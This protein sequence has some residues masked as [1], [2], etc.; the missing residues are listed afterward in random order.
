MPH[1][2]YTVSNT[3]TAVNA[4]PSFTRTVSNCKVYQKL[5][6]LNDATQTWVD[7]AANT[8]L[9]PFATFA[10]GLNT[11][12]TNIGQLTVQATRAL[13]IPSVSWKPTKTYKVKIT[14]DDPDANHLQL[15]TYTFDLEL[16]DICADNALTKTSDLTQVTTHII[17]DPVDTVLTPL[18]TMSVAAAAG[19]GCISVANMSW[20]NTFTNVYTIDNDGTGNT[21]HAFV[22]TFSTVN[23]QL[24]ISTNDIA[25]YSI[26]KLFVMKI[27]LNLPE[28]ISTQNNIEF[29]FQVI[30]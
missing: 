15:L 8:A 9:Y 3:N 22:K 14:L 30:I 10:D 11:A 26:S 23:G 16:R 25:K 2:R 1:W 13:V 28:S 17:E 4:S 5:Y 20:L 7:Y 21:M 18:W 29:P 19:E 6:F 24:A 27:A 12:D